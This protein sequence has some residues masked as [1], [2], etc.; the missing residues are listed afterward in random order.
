MDYYLVIKNN[1]PMPLAATYMD[2]DY[3]TK[4]TMTQK[5]KYMISLICGI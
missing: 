1:E 3:I 4:G 2:L 5:D